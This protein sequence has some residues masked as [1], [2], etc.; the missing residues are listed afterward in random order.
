MFEQSTRSQSTTQS[1]TKIL[2]KPK[3]KWAVK[4]IDTKSNV[5]AQPPINRSKSVPAGHRQQTSLE[6]VRS[7]TVSMQ[8]RMKNYHEELDNIKNKEQERIQQ[9]KDDRGGYS[10]IE[11]LCYFLHFENEQNLRKCLSSPHVGFR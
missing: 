9:H 4:G 3:K 2:N 5:S 10:G 6:I 1:A 7:R 11:V 8:D